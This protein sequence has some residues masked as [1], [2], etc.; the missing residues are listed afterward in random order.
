M[1]LGTQAELQTRLVSLRSRAATMLKALQLSQQ[2]SLASP[3]NP[4]PASHS[5]QEENE[6]A[7]KLARMQ[8]AIVDGKRERERFLN[9]YW[10][11]APY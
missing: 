6:A 10:S 7:T 1:A 11:Q 5:G 9:N 2:M 3:E 8:Q 4:V